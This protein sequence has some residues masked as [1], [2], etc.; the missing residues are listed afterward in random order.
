M[1]GMGD[2]YGKG[3]RNGWQKGRLRESSLPMRSKVK[4]VRNFIKIEQIGLRQNLVMQKVDQFKQSLRIMD[5]EVYGKLLTNGLEQSCGMQLKVMRNGKH[6]Q[7][8][9]DQG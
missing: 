6:R 4:S 3:Q 7:A 1:S 8:Q 9:K 2:I 5:L